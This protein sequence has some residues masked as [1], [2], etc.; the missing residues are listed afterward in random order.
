MAA[1]SWKQRFK[2]QQMQ[3]MQCHR[4][5]ILTSSSMRRHIPFRSIL[6]Y[7][8]VPTVYCSLSKFVNRKLQRRHL[9]KLHFATFGQQLLQHPAKQRSPEEQV[10]QPTTWQARELRGDEEENEEEESNKK[11]EKEEKRNKPTF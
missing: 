8:Q 5:R 1:G 10:P 6:A 7:T 2:V 9:A 3:Q 4:S 11:K